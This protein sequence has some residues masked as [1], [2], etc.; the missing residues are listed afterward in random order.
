LV[1]L[2]E[3][4]PFATPKRFGAEMDFWGIDVDSVN[5]D[6]VTTRLWWQ[7]EQAP[8]VNYSISLR[9]EDA[10][11][12]IIAQND[13]P[14]KHY[15][16]EVVETSQFQPRKIYVDWRTLDLPQGLPPGNY[17]LQLVVYRSWDGGRLLLPNGSDA[18][19]LDTF[20][21]S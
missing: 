6:A 3:A 1:Q 14:I 11:G 4:P 10:N 7:V 21:I 2:M 16:E 13:G 15:G 17:T 20:T 18:L 5:R 12:G 9:I 8:S 19:K